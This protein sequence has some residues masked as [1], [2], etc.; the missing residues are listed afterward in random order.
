MIEPE[1]Y[2]GPFVILYAVGMGWSVG[3]YP[4]LPD[5]LDR[6]RTFACKSEAWRY[7]QALWSEWRLPFKDLSAGNTGRDQ[8][9]IRARQK[10]LFPLK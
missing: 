8:S 6:S 1:A 2:T 9:A 10:S 4:P 7:A 5:G 3:V